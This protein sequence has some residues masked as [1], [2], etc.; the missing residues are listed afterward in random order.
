VTMTI[1]RGPDRQK[2]EIPLK[3]ELISLQELPT[4]TIG[5]NGVAI[6]HVTTFFQRGV[7]NRVHALVR[8]AQSRDAKAIVLDMRA[9]GGGWSDEERITLGAFVNNPE[10]YRRVPRYNAETQTYE[11]L[12]KDGR[13]IVR[14][15]KGNERGSQ[16]VQ[17]PTLWTGPLTVLVDGGCASACEYVSA[18]IQRAKRAPVVGE[19]TVG[20]GNTNS[21]EFDLVNGGAVVM[22]T[23]RT[24][25]ADGTLFPAQI[26]P[27][28]LIADGA[29]TLF[30]TGR[31]V[32]L[33]K[34][35]EVLKIS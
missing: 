10:P 19:P 16:A 22:P 1:V 26:T 31:D 4:M 9:N 17:N 15:L 12:Y 28:V 23:L 24:T 33:E 32:A 11:E 8:E 3:G 20:V 35:L 2:L 21:A 7:G 25:W 13:W 18:S 6:I 5:A 30:E 14:D 29:F 27:D 34:A